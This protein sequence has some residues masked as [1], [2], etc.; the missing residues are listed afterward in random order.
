MERNQNPDLVLSGG[1]E[2]RQM[3]GAST[4]ML[5]G[6]AQ[7]TCPSL[8]EGLVPPTPSDGDLGGGDSP[9]VNR[10]LTPKELHWAVSIH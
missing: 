4:V 6:Q 8:A 2:V 3:L 7:D 5:S 1:G 9:M 10:L